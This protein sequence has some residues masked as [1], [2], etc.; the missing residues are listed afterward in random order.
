MKKVWELGPTPKICLS[1]GKPFPLFPS[2]YSPEFPE[3][4]VSRSMRGLHQD[5]VE[6]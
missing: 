4:K 5:I 3:N 1:L 2:H 6:T